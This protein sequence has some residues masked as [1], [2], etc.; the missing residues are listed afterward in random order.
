[1]WVGGRRKNW[2]IGSA[3]QGIV[4]GEDKA[5]K[6]KTYG[7]GDDPNERNGFQQEKK[8]R[9]SAKEDGIISSQRPKPS[10]ALVAES[11]GGKQPEHAIA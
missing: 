5:E 8:L 9:K 11:E 7:G 10:C 4:K 6:E 1:M 2:S 3:G